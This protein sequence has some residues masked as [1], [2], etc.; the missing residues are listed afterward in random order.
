MRDASVLLGCWP[1]NSP[2]RTRAEHFHVGERVKIV[3]SVTS[4]LSKGET[5]TVCEP[6][7]TR[8]GRVGVH[9][10]RDRG[11]NP[12]YFSPSELQLVD[13]E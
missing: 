6:D 7:P 8:P 3:D 9:L 4:P 10:S 2:E 11:W 5:G 12:I 13:P 1:M